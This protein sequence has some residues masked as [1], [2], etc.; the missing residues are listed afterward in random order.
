M[1]NEDIKKAIEENKKEIS[2]E[3]LQKIL[4][5]FDSCMPF[6]GPFPILESFDSE[7]EISLKKKKKGD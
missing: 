5:Y 6:K 7:L 4:K 2:D 3:D 1:K